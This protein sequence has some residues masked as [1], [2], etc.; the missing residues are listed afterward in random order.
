MAPPVKL[1]HAD[2]QYKKAARVLD[3]LSA[4]LFSLR[5]G[6]KSKAYCVLISDLNHLNAKLGAVADTPPCIS[7]SRK[8]QDEYAARVSVI[9]ANV[10]D[11]KVDLYLS[12]EYRGLL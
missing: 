7:F 1:S 9:R 2:K 5:A 4:R 6:A 8:L 10:Y 11:T 12:R 3:D